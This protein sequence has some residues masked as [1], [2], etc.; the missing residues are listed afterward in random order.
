MENKEIAAKIQE[1][2]DKLLYLVE[3]YKTETVSVQEMEKGLLKQLLQIGLESL[4][5]IIESKIED[6]KGF[7]PKAEAGEKLESKGTKDRKYLSIFGLI[8]LL[9]GM[10]WSKKRGSYYELDNCLNLPPCLWSYNIQEWVGE[11]AS[12]NDFRESVKIF[13][14]LLGLNLN[15]MGSKRNAGR[16]GFS[17]D[18]YY[19]NKKI[20]EKEY[21]KYFS[22]SFD[23]KGV[24][25]IIDKKTQ[26]GNPKKRLGKG[27][28]RGCKQEATVVVTSSFEPKKRTKDKIIRS[29]MGSGLSKVVPDEKSKELCDKNDN[30]W[31]ENIH[32]RAFLANQGKAIEYGL[33]YIRTR[34]K[35]PDCRFVIPIDAGVGLEPKV[36]A[37]VKKHMMEEQ[38]DG[39]IIDIIHVSEYVWDTATALFGEKSIIRTSWVREMLEDLLDSKTDLV[40][41]DLERIRDKTTLTE[42]Q[43]KQVIKTITYFSNNGHNMDYKNF[44]KKGY[45]VSSALVESAC[46]HLVKERMEG[47][48]MRWSSEGAQNILDLRAVKQND[49]MIDFMSFVIKQEHRKQINKAA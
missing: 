27:E 19:D 5:Y 9:R 8:E 3:D 2:L 38:F 39:I 7:R 24:P 40:I 10:H 14:K 18:A 26:I 48:G 1:E 36:L 37:Y 43:R 11:S 23:G 47:S 49:D 29:L 4:R 31:H 6:L 41:R 32:R 13:N 12:E 21:T 30:R 42:T 33:D 20:E 35:T 17:V 15:D 46:G 28:K 45:P 22:A 16:L 25:K 44:I 34:I